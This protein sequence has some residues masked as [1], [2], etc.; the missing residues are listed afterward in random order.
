MATLIYD[1][2]RIQLLHKIFYCLDLLSFHDD[3][4]TPELQLGIPTK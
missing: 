1:I 2:S 3:S 4:S